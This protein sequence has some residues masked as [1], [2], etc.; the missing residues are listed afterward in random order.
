MADQL[1]IFGQT[2]GGISLEDLE[3]HYWP[4]PDAIV[5][6]LA[7]DAGIEDLFQGDPDPGPESIDPEELQRYI[8]MQC[9]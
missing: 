5:K 2:N 9:D 8:L 1:K 3:R 6:Q 4:D 7:T